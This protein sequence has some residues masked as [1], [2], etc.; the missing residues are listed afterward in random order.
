MFS[1]DKR[2]LAGFRGEKD[3]R[4]LVRTLPDG[5]EH[6]AVNLRPNETRFWTVA[7]DASWLALVEPKPSKRVR[8]LDGGTGNERFHRDFEDAVA[9]IATSPDAKVLAVGLNDVGRGANNKIVLLDASRNDFRQQQI[10]FVALWG[11]KL[12]D[13]GSELRCRQCPAAWPDIGTAVGQAATFN[14][15]ATLNGASVFS[16]NSASVTSF[17]N[18]RRR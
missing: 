16:Y 2:F 7:P 5:G 15:A 14:P 12:R 18:A 1:R 9:C 6:A 17:N 3:D 11:M 4:V 10:A 8:V 13:I